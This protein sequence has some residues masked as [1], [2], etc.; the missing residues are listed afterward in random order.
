[1]LAATKKMATY[2]DEVTKESHLETANYLDACNKLFENGILSHQI[3][4]S[5]GS[6]VLQN[7]KQGFGY[8]KDWH[9]QLSD[10]DTG[11]CSNSTSVELICWWKPIY[12]Y[13]YL[14]N[15]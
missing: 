9:Q 1:M 8:F 4:D 11:T 10:S 7:M 3:I 15:M 13:M 5:L 6:P 2:R 14:F 12:T